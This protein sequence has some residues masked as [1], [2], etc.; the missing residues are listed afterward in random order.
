MSQPKLEGVRC[1]TPISCSA[2]GDNILIAAPG[3]GQY[4]AIDFI[5]FIPNS[6]VTAT[7]KSGSTAIS[8]AM[9]LSANQGLVF[10]N[11]AQIQEGILKKPTVGKVGNAEAF[12]LNL[13]G[14]V[15]VSG[16]ISYRIVGYKQI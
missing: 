5:A 10:D 1:Q 11:S 8:G 13:G 12:I 7:F 9:S 16:T 4:I 3:A 14:A 2:S 6:A 15:Q